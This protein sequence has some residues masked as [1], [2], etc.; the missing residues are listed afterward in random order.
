ME[1]KSPKMW[2]KLD[3]EV[4]KII[5]KVSVMALTMYI[6]LTIFGIAA[7]GWAGAVI[8]LKL[9]SVLVSLMLVVG[10][11]GMYVIW[12]LDKIDKLY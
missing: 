9:F 8:V 11:G 7:G 5:L 1:I 12:A 3:S 10:I 4:K 6:I 2:T